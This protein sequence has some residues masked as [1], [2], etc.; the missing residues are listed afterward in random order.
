[1]KQK[2]LK[3]M[4]LLC[5]GMMGMSAW[6][7][8]TVTK[9]SFSSTSGKVDDDDPNVTYT[10]KQGG[11]TTNATIYS[12]AIRLYQNAGGATGGYV[13]IG[14][15][16]GYVITSATIQSTT[17]TT[18][19]YKLTDSAPTTTPAK[20]T[21]NVNNH[22]L[23]ANTDYTVN[24]ISSRYITF[25]CFGTTNGTRLNLSKISVTYISETKTTTTI[26]ASGITNNNV[27]T[28]TEAGTLSASVTYDNSG[29]PTAVP[30]ASVTWTSSNSSVATISSDGAVTLV[31]VGNTTIQASYTGENGYKSSS[32][33]YNLKVTD[34]NTNTHDII[35]QSVTTITGSSYE[36]KENITSS[37]NAIYTVYCAGSNTSVQFNDGKN[38][39]LFSTTT[40]GY[41]RKVK[42]TWNSKTTSGRTLNVYGKNTPYVKDGNNAYVLY[43]NAT[44]GE[45]LG[46]I[47][48]GTSTELTIT[49]NYAYIGLCSNSGAMY[50]TEIDIT[51]EDAY[52]RN[53]TNG[54]YGTICLPFSV[55]LT[56]STGATYY[57][58]AGVT[59]NGDAINGIS[60]AEVTGNTLVAGTPY[61]FK[62]TADKLV[63]TY[64]TNYVTTPVAATGLVGN[65]GTAATINAGEYIYILGTDN[66][67]HKLSGTATAT[68]AT[69]RAYLNLEGVAEAP[70]SVKGVRLYFDGSEEATAITEITEKTEGTEGVIYNLQGQRVNSLQRGINIV[71]GKKVLVK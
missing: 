32:A 6:G 14:V 68:V 64:S 47:V 44:K 65:L 70:A 28:S 55:D 29:T 4:C 57:T 30:G 51:W 27:L 43:N 34:G 19:G 3:L 42:V 10:A 18:T 12:N 41:A 31:G 67:M 16:E 23:A 52:T 2:L 50:L 13:Y 20:N 54:N 38:A 37:S 22:S 49:G 36:L 26:D 63:A 45:L 48:Y 35:N 53:V 5:V 58:V 8:T 66:K 17:A 9:T 71:G 7:Q 56:K 61:I 62:A 69:N 25:A 40:G 59:K 39:G 46:T 15:P 33:T 60:L 24:G 21:F 1:M 11:G